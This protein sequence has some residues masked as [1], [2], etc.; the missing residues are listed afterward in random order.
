MSKRP[1]Q[2]STSVSPRTS[3]RCVPKLCGADVELGNFIIGPKAA[4]DTGS[5]AARR[6]LR[7]IVGVEQGQPTSSLCNCDACKATRQKEQEAHQASNRASGNPYTSYE[8]DTGRSTN[9]GWGGGSTYVGAS[10]SSNKSGQGQYGGS[11]GGYQGGYASYNVQDWG[12][13][14]LANNGGCAYID[15]DHLELCLP[16]VLSAHDHLAAWHAMLHIA[17][18][19]QRTA[20]E[21]LGQGRRIQVLVNNSDGLGNSYGSHLNFLISRQA[22]ENIFHLKLHPMLFLAAHQASS[23]VITGQGKVGAE[24]GANPVDYQLSQRADFLETLCALQTTYRRPLVNKRDEPLCGSQRFGNLHTSNSNSGDWHD[25]ERSSDGFARLHV[26]FYD[27]N[28]CHVA[29]LLKVGMLQ[30][31]LAMIEADQIDPELILDSPLDAV[32]SF[33]HDPTLQAHARLANGKLITAVELQRRFLEGAQRFVDQGGCLGIVPRAEE[34]VTLWWDTLDKLQSRDWDALQPRLDW[35]LKQRILQHAMQK[36]PNLNWASPELKH[37]D[38]LYG[39]LELEQGLYWAYERQGCTEQLVSEADIERFLREPP[40]DTRAWGRTMLLRRAGSQSIDAVDWD[41][42]RLRMTSNRSWPTYRSL[43]LANPLAYT[44]ADTQQ[45]FD[46][47][48][49]LADLYRG[50]DELYRDHDASDASNSTAGQSQASTSPGTSL[51]LV[52]VKDL[53]TSESTSDV[54]SPDPDANSSRDRA[55][56]SRRRT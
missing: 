2:T 25:R 40:H 4:G 20:N 56:N 26:I 30:I 9:G 44:R 19:A 23:I 38:H 13:K 22:W 12:R 7:E 6:L 43:D 17:R 21:R 10:Q 39:S 34:I 35:V 47:A 3:T 51:A 46:T 1:M 42:V 37:L 8:V 52:P 16:E 18:D 28:L 32:R 45:V 41:A 33:S 31:L 5:E 15:L 54:S 36:R 50:L 14:F 53:A 55:V 29:H 48:T 49:S 24:N 11:S 27:S